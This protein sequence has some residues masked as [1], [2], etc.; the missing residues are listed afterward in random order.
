MPFNKKGLIRYLNR[1]PFT[2]IHRYN[3][4]TGKIRLEKRKVEANMSMIEEAFHEFRSLNIL[5]QDFKRINNQAFQISFYP[6]SRTEIHDFF[7]QDDVLF[8]Y[9]YR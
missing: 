7:E 5:I 8:N 1:T 9:L 6:L 3:F 4:F 2:D